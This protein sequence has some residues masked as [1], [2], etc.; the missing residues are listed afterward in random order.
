M[1]INL[2]DFIQQKDWETQNYGAPYS[3]GYVKKT[4]V[5]FSKE[6]ERIGL[7]SGKIVYRL[8][9]RSEGAREVTPL[10]SNFLIPKGAKLYVYDPAKKTVHGAYTFATHPQA[11]AFSSMP[12]LG[13]EVIFEYEPND[14]GEMPQLVISGLVHNYRPVL[15]DANDEE[16]S[17][18]FGKE[19]N[20]NCVQGD[21][22]KDQ[23]AG[24][25]KM[26]MVIG[27][28][29]GFCTG[30]L[31]NNTNQDFKPYILSAAHCAST[32]TSFKPTSTD[33]NQWQ[34]F[35]HYEKPSCANS[36]FSLKNQVKTMIGCSRK[37]FL[38]IAGQ[39][40]GLLVQLNQTVPDEY[41]VYYNGWD[42]STYVNN[43]DIKGLV[44]IHHPAGDVKKISV[45]YP[46]SDLQIS[47]WT[48]PNGYPKAHYFFKYDEGDTEG[49]SSGSSIFANK[50]KLVIG[51]LTGGG[52]GTQ[53]YGRLTYHWDKF[54]EKMSQYLDPKTNGKAYTCQGTYKND[55]KP[56]YP[57]NDITVVNGSNERE[58][59]ITWK[60][61]Y[62][63]KYALDKY[64]SKAVSYTLSRNGTPIVGK[65]IYDDGSGTMKFVDSDIPE[66]ALKGG[67]VKY[68]IRV[69]YAFPKNQGGSFGF[70]SEEAAGMVQNLVTTIKPKSVSL[71]SQGTGTS[72]KWSAPLYPQEWSKIGVGITEYAPKNMLSVKIGYSQKLDFGN[73]DG[74]KITQPYTYYI[75]RWSPGI[76]P[77]SVGNDK[78][79][80][81][82]SQLDFIPNNTQVGKSDLYV[83]LSYDK[84]VRDNSVYKK[85][86]IQKV[87]VAQNEVGKWKHVV[88]DHPIPLD[89]SNMLQIGFR[90]TNMRNNPTSLTYMSGSSDGEKAKVA[91]AHMLFTNYN[92]YGE[93]GYTGEAIFPLSFVG[94][95]S[96]D[97]NYMAMKV[98]VTSSFEKLD[99]PIT[100]PD[101][102]S[103]V[104][105]IPPVV[106]GY[107]VMK[108]GKEIATTKAISLSYLDRDNKSG[109]GN[110]EI[111]PI[112]NS[113]SLDTQL[114]SK[115]QMSKVVPTMVEST[116][117]YSGD[118]A[119]IAVYS[120]NGERVAFVA[121]VENGGS[122]DLQTLE[123]G[124]YLVVM[125]TAEGK[126]EQK[127]VKK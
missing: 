95:P 24:V 74:Q 38:P 106:T 56:V 115:A 23:K 99:A 107:K 33:L 94:V 46:N 28:G 127:I 29:A 117:T 93:Y 11:G 45:L 22:W 9:M 81:Y 86:V 42:R 71:N 16:E 47:T 98:I 88:F 125:T 97:L 112:Y 76:L 20:V 32:T 92:H 43:T 52:L 116:V 118:V 51:T 26:Y 110:Y 31:M 85:Q 83:Y 2:S 111:V 12:V 39:S 69:S 21:D 64:G 54:P 113:Q 57:V 126:V 53:Y 101:Y 7:S 17:S 6:A 90:S 41:R 34:F 30:D 67:V 25:C 62:N 49:G 61:P 82:V 10:Y 40:D 65:R 80:L 102:S 66:V 36:S 120:M 84:S 37:A 68:S 104:F 75:E 1:D 114:V 8:R 77:E 48:K 119:D 13:D 14:S 58:F 59:I 60:S 70:D 35:F 121:N 91:S 15:F 87:S 100:Q 4:N 124:S 27:N 72:I 3:V 78:L 122:I 123:P 19:I 109:E 63:A 44:G 105:S 5:D 79:S 89:P 73:G 103:S 96:V 108:D 50:N 18:I 55:M